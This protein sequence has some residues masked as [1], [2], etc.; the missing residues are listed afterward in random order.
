LEKY[1]K[2]SSEKRSCSLKQLQKMN[3]DATLKSNS[4]GECVVYSIGSFNEWD[5]EEAILA[6]TNCRVETFDCTLPPTVTGPPVALQ[7]RVRL[8]KVCLGSSDYIVN[9]KQFLSW[10]SLHKLTGVKQ[11][12]NYLKID[13]EGY[14]FP[15]MLSI[16][17]SGQQL[18]L[19]I[20][21][22]IHTMRMEKGAYVSD[23]LADTGELYSFI[24]FLYK[25]GGYYLVDRNDNP[26]C[27]FCTEI[28]LAKL[29]C[30][31]SPSNEK[32]RQAL[33]DENNQHKG[34]ASR[35]KASMD[36]TYYV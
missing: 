2:G 19:Q 9:E 13:I 7:S 29:R 3:G 26:E 6:T 23:Y 20:A 35:M 5:F 28:L 25:F 22:E 14:E 10:P 8:H 1:G 30:D 31:S 17:N 33:I 4:S 34:F 11:S 27:S 18:P 16:I 21:M 32:Y 15:V 24:H 36:A 12:P